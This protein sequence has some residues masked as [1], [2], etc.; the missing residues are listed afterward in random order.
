MGCQYLNPP[1]PTPEVIQLQEA[2]A[3][4]SRVL[5]PARVVPES[6]LGGLEFPTLTPA[7]TERPIGWSPEWATQQARGPSGTGLDGGYV[8]GRE[9][10]VNA[11]D[12]LFVVDGASVVTADELEE[13]DL[14][15]PFRQGTSDYLAGLAAEGDPEFACVAE[16]RRRLAAYEPSDYRGEELD[17]FVVGRLSARFVDEREDCAELGWAAE[18]ARDGKRI[19]QSRS[20]PSNLPESRQLAVPDSLWS[21]ERRLPE[22]GATRKGRGHVIV[23]FQRFPFRDV[24]G[25]WFYHD[26]ARVWAWEAHGSSGGDDV[27]DGGVDWPEFP[28]CWAAVAEQVGLIAAEEGRVIDR[29]LVGLV[30]DRIRRQGPERCDSERWRAVPRELPGQGCPVLEPMGRQEDGSVL[31]HWAAHPPHYYSCWIWQVGGWQRFARD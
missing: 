14:G 24:A 22:L 7:P 23:H 8:P 18:A 11:G 15:G 19:C 25:C 2:G 9:R 4:E 6:V 17:G 16:F 26:S 31:A 20:L 3:G 1:A 27:I 30:V 5:Q 28:E 21:T 13:L 10:V 29:D 12:G